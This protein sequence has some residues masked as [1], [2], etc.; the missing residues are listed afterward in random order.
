MK[1]LITLTLL[2]FLVLLFGTTVYAQKLDF[3]ASGFIDA[4][5][6]LARNVPYAYDIPPWQPFYAWLPPL[7]GPSPL[8]NP[9]SVTGGAPAL[10]RSRSLMETRAR[11]KFDMVM[12]KSLS[13]TI[14]FEMDSAM[15]GDPDGTRNS[16]GFWGADRAGL[17]IK[18]V[19]IDFGVPAI[20]IPVTVRVGVQ[21]LAIRPHMVVYDDGAGITAGIKVD[22]LTIQPLW[23]K[24]L[25][26]KDFS[27][28]D[29][30]IY[31][32]Q[33]SSKIEKIT[34]GGYGLYYNQNTYPLFLASYTTGF[35]PS[36][37]N[38]DATFKSDMWWLGVYGEGKLGPVDTNFD[39]VVDTGKVEDARNIAVRASDVKYRGWATRLSVDYPWEKFNF[40]VV[41]VYASGSDQKKTDFTGIPG[42]TTPFGTRT[43][44][45]SGYVVPIASE[46]FAYGESL[47]LTGSPIWSGFLGYS[48]LNYKQMHRGSIGGT[49]VAKLYESYKAAPWYKVTLSG[50]YIGDTT[51]NGNT[52]GNARRSNGL[53]RDDKTIGFEFDLINEINIYKNL[54]F[55]IGLGYLFTGDALQYFD[56]ATNRNKDG[57]DPWALITR[58][59]YTF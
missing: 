51:K 6:F 26:G 25:E 23:F 39:F 54:K 34:V 4:A 58:L 18:N 37:P 46:Q 31:G 49:W 29:V 7:Y 15:W 28:D 40:G 55:D 13:G 35:T 52:I 48:V 56:A 2:W 47:L 44:R 5:S 30:D 32:L 59:T 3:R 9:A 42:Q 19:Y 57:K 53:P 14:F 24:A 21:P 17:E 20:P 1:K 11:L 16:I 41:G 50:I 43:T 38:I 10:D 36:K 27:A 8:F 33:V 12:D 45:V 22:P